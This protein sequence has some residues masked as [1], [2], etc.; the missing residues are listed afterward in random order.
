MKRKYISLLILVVLGFLFSSCGSK[1]VSKITP[2]PAP[3]IIEMPKTERPIISLVPRDDG[4]MLYLKFENIPSYIA[5]IE[6]EVLYNAIDEGSEIE[7]GVGDTIKEIT[8]NLERKILLGTESCTNGCKYKYDSGIVGGTLTIGLIDKNGQMSTFE[9]QFSLKS[10]ADI[11]KNGEIKLAV[12]DFSV[13]PNS[14]L[15]GK[16][17]YVLMA[18]YRGGYSI[19]SNSNNPFV[20]DYPKP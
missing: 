11:N 4:H 5:Q 14:K 19:Y 1:P 7:K 13:K 3:K 8:P 16:D 9:T 15:T 18:N 2:T 17:Y 12:E 6:Y 10:T 20:G